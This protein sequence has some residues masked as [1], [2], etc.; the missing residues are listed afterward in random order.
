MFNGCKLLDDDDLN[1]SNWDVSNATT[2]SYM[3][4]G[5]ESLTQMDL[6]K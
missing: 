3:F 4:A 2:F 6:H 5:C 1:L